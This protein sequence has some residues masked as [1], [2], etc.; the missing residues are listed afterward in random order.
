MAVPPDGLIYV[1]SDWG[2]LKVT[3]YPSSNTCTVIL[4]EEGRRG[5]SGAKLSILGKLFLQQ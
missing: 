4:R 3:H 1:Q 5:D 2:S